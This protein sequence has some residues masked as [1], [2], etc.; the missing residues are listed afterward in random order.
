M[1][2]TEAN[3]K[4]IKKYVDANREK[5]NEYINSWR[6]E[7]KESVSA[8]RKR[9]YNLNRDSDYEVAAKAFRRILL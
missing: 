2:Y 6:R 8:N 3:K 5:I 1:T 7:N 9:I 4:A